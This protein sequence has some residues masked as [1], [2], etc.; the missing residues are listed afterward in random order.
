MRML[1]WAAGL[2]LAAAASAQ[3]GGAVAHMA[4]GSSVPLTSWTLSYEYVAWKPGTPQHQAPPQRRDTAE[5][6]L[7]K[8]SFPV[9]GRTLE[10]VYSA[11][12]KQREIDGAVETVKVKV[13][14]GFALDVG[15][16]KSTLKLE[17]PHRDAIIPGA[18]KGLLLAVRTVDL[19][20]QTL[21]G[22]RREFC[23]AS[24]TSLV[25]CPEDAAN[26]VLRVEFQ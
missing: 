21:T 13:A 16:K 18:E 23:L 19:K 14:S 1:P 5:L 12:P 3:E 17:A 4:D 6:L 22:T 26:Q 9:K 25:E 15:G 11:V 8:R 10:V 2:A 20:G 24:F 7:A